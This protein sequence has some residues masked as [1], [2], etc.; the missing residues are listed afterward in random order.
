MRQGKVDVA[1]PSSPSSPTWMQLPPQQRSALKPLSSQW[2][3]LSETHKKKWLNVTSGF[4]QMPEADRL[5]LHARMSEWA[6]LSQKQRQ[7]ARINYFQV[8][9][10]P[11]EQRKAQW[12]AYQSLSA[13]EKQKLAAA[14]A[15]KKPTGAAVA[16]KPAPVPK[17]AASSTQATP[18]SA[19]KALP[20]ASTHTTEPRAASVPTQ[21][22][23]PHTLMPRSSASSP[24]GR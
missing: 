2:D 4:A 17:L 16:I 20:N 12:E 13:E 9:Q 21:K 3:H 15:A 1:A 19:R 11:A 14:A 8:S 6:A 5:R 23:D 18:L 22:L 7:Q 24:A 10:I